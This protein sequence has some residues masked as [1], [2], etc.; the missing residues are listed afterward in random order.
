MEASGSSA[1]FRMIHPT[2]LI[3][4]GSEAKH[5]VRVVLPSEMRNVVATNETIE[6]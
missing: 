6:F 3:F 1:C 5:R 2:T 4:R